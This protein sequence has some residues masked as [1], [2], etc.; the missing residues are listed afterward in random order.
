[1][2]S[3]STRRS[4]NR[5][6]PRSGI[7]T[8]VLAALFLAGVAVV[9][10]S[11]DDGDIQHAADRFKAPT[12]KTDPS[13][14]QRWKEEDQQLWTYVN[15]HVPDVLDHTGSSAFDQ[16]LKGV[17]AVLRY[18]DAPTYLTNAGLFHSIYGTEGFQ[19]FSL[20]LKER[21]AIQKLIGP[22]AEWLCF[23]FCMVDRYTFDE[24]VMAW[25]SDDDV[26]NK[27]A[28]Y[29]VKSRPEL[30]RFDI[31]LTKEEWLDF[32]ALSL[33]DW[34][35]QV[36]GA[37]SKPSDLF[38]WKTG[39]AYAYRRR[40]YRKMVDIL[41]SE[42]PERLSKIPKAMYIAVMETESNETRHLVQD[43]TP[44]VSD[45]GRRAVEALRAGGVAIPL[46]LTPQPS[47]ITTTGSDEL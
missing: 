26:G 24:T 39:E 14:I 12:S 43:R 41:A 20:P 5:T 40:A 47:R 21:A 19:G 9:S 7:W 44:P 33:A 1:M 17:Q 32:V 30:G 23:V 4:I 11:D 15:E 16:H 31:T 28:T 27:T 22:T 37:S 38:L 18:W 29:T 3:S 45:A 2:V 42:K 8:V 46:D 13:T 6:L 10:G 34:L 35:E 36:E 25:T